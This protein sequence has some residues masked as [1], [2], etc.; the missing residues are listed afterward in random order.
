[1]STSLEST[2]WHRVLT[3]RPIDDAP[4]PGERRSRVRAATWLLEGWGPVVVRLAMSAEVSLNILTAR[5]DCTRALLG[6]AAGATAGPASAERLWRDTAV[7]WGLPRCLRCGPHPAYL[8]PAFLA[9][10]HRFGYRR[11]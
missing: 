7:L 4:S 9:C 5:D 8:E 11:A 3:A 1:M 2:T 6:L 10:L